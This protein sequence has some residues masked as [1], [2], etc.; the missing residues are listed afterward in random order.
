M[1]VLL[2]F[3]NEFI[4]TLSGKKFLGSKF[5]MPIVD[6]EGCVQMPYVV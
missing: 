5:E 6:K 4:N 1:G 2:Q 3:P